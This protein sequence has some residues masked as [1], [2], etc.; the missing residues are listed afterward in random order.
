[1]EF[2]LPIM[3]QNGKTIGIDH[4]PALVSQSI[5]NVEDSGYKM[6]IDDGTLGFAVADGRMGYAQEAPYDVIHIGA[7]VPKLP[8]VIL[9]QLKP[10]GILVAPVGPEGNQIF[11]VITKATPENITTRAIAAVRYIPLTSANRQLENE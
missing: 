9:S 11:Q 7:G 2:L 4:I 1:M 5:K 6:L 10:H 3:R 8:E